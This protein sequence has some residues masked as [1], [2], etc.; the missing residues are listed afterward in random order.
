MSARPLAL[1]TG[2]LRRIGAA[3][4]ARLAEAGYDLALHAHQPGALEAEAAARLAAAGAAHHCFVADLADGAAPPELLA[5]VIATCG[6]APRLLVNNASRFAEDR[7]ESVT[8]ESLH[9]HYA[10]NCVAPVLLARDVAAA[11]AGPGAVIVNLLDQRIAAPHGDQFAYTLAKL[12]LAGATEILARELAPGARVC[13]VAP[14]LTLA[15]PDYGD[16]G[17]ARAAALMPLGRTPS[18][19]AIAEAVAY[20][21]QAESVTGQIL[22]VDGGAHLRHYPRDFVYLD[23]AEARPAPLNP[24]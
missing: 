14:G 11:A 9:L 10:V 8:A 20:L 13:G 1:V 6:R 19:A 16:T 4:A 23:G 12:A 2:G 3:V 17:L 5:E 22:Y 15:T 21:A 7:P 18:A 24:A